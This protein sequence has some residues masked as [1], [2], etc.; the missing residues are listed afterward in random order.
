MESIF[1]LPAH[2]L[3]VHFPIVLMPLVGLVAVAVAL[4]PEWRIRFGPQL[5]GSALVVAVATIL[6]AGSGEPFEDLLPIG[7]LAN[8]HQSLGETTR[9]LTIL[10]FV[11]TVVMAAFDWWAARSARD[12]SETGSLSALRTRAGVI[13]LSLGGVSA[14]LAILATIWMIRTG[15]EGARITWDGILPDEG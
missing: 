2:P 13:G 9:L 15:H 4:R 5:A 11:V 8:K 10:F 14:V 3:F 12:D 6:A 1:D 7:D